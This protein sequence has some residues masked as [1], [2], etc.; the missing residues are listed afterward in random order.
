[1]SDSQTPPPLNALRAFEAAGRH[2]NFRAAAD[3]LAVTQGA[4]SQHV[5]GLEKA[6]GVRLFERHARGV[7][8]TSPGHAY[9]Q[10]VGAAFR[11]LR[12]ATAILQPESSRVTISVTPTFA[13]R[14]L[15]PNLA[16][17]TASHPHIDLR[18]LST[19]RT[20]SFQHDGIDL[21]VRQGNPPFGAQLDTDLL[22]SQ[23]II[24]VATPELVAG[25]PLPLTA[26]DIDDLPRLHDS[27][28][29]WPSFLKQTLNVAGIHPGRN[30]HFSQTS[31]S[32]EAALA[33]QGV[34]LV[35][36]FLVERELESGRL[37]QVIESAYS[38]NGDFYLLS[39]RT[40]DA[41]SVKVV[42]QWLLDL[43]QQ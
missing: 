26:V 31:L 21:A 9:H 18:V 34:A 1:M 15:I 19:E 8:F 16:G 12:E 3:E 29:L 27:H 5:R 13:S 14:W 10:E 33:S 23:S 6:L 30:L 24:A 39:K 41:R 32:V 35:S 2:L 7:A 37:I 28:S 4:I 22:F 17:F 38:G 11:A 40:S 36:R 43:S 25:R 20:L 42:R